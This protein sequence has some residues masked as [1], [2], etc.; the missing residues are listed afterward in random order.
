M[1]TDL[2][3]FAAAGTDP[4]IYHLDAGFKHVRC[5]SFVGPSNWIGSEI[6][7]ADL[8]AASPGSGLTSFGIW[9][10]TSPRVYFVASTLDIIEL[11]HFGDNWHWQDLTSVSNA[12][13]AATNSPLASFPV[14]ADRAYVYYLDASGNV[15]EL[16]FSSQTTPVWTN[17]NLMTA[18]DPG[19][20]RAA[21]ESPLVAF[22]ITGVA[23]GPRVY[24]IAANSMEVIEIAY[25]GGKWYWQ[26]LASIPAI[27]P[28]V[29]YAEDEKNPRL[30]YL[31]T[32]KGDVHLLA[33]SLSSTP[34]WIDTNL[35]SK[36]SAPDAAPT[37]ALAVQQQLKQADWI[38]MARQRLCSLSWF[39]KEKVNGT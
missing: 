21:P 26:N 14:A 36:I 22:E 8:P 38:S 33:Y 39:M 11:G 12:P 30:F 23:A 18:T 15:Q 27:S 25:F 4:R 10:A 19:P 2:T 5:L 1:A 34:P 9:G 32:T 7:L 3:G 37:S 24:Y 20:P 17:T 35:T 13:S 31:D 6:E 28:M 29:G 16:T